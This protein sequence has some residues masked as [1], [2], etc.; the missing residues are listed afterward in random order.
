[1]RRLRRNGGRPKTRPEDTAAGS[2]T[3]H[4][5]SCISSTVFPGQMVMGLLG[6]SG[7]AYG[8]LCLCERN[9]FCAQKFRKT[10][11]LRTKLSS[12]NDSSP[13]AYPHK[14]GLRGQ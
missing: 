5:T 8:D 11:C 4:G 7:G 2:K 6:A 10:Q 9:R 13:V 14:R 12:C 3:H 1:M